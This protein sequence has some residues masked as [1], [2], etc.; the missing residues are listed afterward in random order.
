MELPAQVGRTQPHH[1]ERRFGQTE[2]V[3]AS[4]TSSSW[5]RPSMAQTPRLHCPLPTGPLPHGL[6]V[7]LY[8]TQSSQKCEAEN[9]LRMTTV[10]PCSRHCPIP[11]MFPAERQP[12]KPSVPKHLQPSLPGERTGK[13]EAMAGSQQWGLCENR[14]RQS[15]PGPQAQGRRH[16]AVTRRAALHT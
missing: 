1:P 9:F 4:P 16:M 10:I 5:A 8:F 7:Q 13:A 3:Q 12:G 15:C 6:T 2:L 14:T 11:T